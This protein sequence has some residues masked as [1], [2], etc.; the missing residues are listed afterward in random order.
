MQEQ[1][2][3]SY[4]ISFEVEGSKALFTDPLSRIGKEKNSYPVPTASALRGICENIYW[5]P[6]IDYRITECRVMNEI[7]YEAINQSV[8]HI[9]DGKNDL[10][11]YKY[12]KNVRYQV[13]GYMIP[14]PKRPDL[15]E[16]YGPKHLDIFQRS[17][18]AGGRY[19]PYLGSSECM[20]FVSPA[21]FGDGEGYYDNL[22]TLHI[23]VMYNV[24]DYDQN[25]RAKGTVLFD[26][27]MRRGT[28]RFPAEE[29][30]AYY[31]IKYPEKSRA[32]PQKEDVDL[33]DMPETVHS[34]QSLRQLYPIAVEHTD[35]PK[36]R[37]LPP[38]HIG[39]TS[40]ITVV[41]T[42]NGKFSGAYANNADDAATAIPVTLE[43]ACRTAAPAPH[44]L[45][46]KLEYLCSEIPTPKT[47]AYMKQINELQNPPAEV[48]AIREYLQAQTLTKDIAFLRDEKG[49]VQNS[50]VAF[51]DAVVRFLVGD[52]KTWEATHIQAYFDDVASAKVT[53]QGL[54]Y[55]TGQVTNTTIR[56][57]GKIRADADMTKL[58]SS[59]DSRGLVFRDG[60][61]ADAKECVSL[62]YDSSQQALSTLRWLIR[63][64][65]IHI[66]SL[67]CLLWTNHPEQNYG[68]QL[69]ELI[70]QWDDPT[71]AT[72]PIT[73]V[74]WLLLDT[75]DGQ[76]TKGRLS[77]C[78][79]GF[80]PGSQALDNLRYWYQSNR[81][82][83]W[84][85]K[86]W[87][88]G[89]P[90]L[91]EIIHT[92]YGAAGKRWEAPEAVL[93]LH[94]R[95]LIPGILQG[96]QSKKTLLRNLETRI[97]QPLKL[98]SWN[99][100]AC[101]QVYRALTQVEDIDTQSLAYQAGRLLRNYELLLYN[102]PKFADSFSN[103]WHPFVLH[104]QTAWA[105]QM[106]PILTILS[107][108]VDV[109]DILDQRKTLGT[110]DN[111]HMNHHDLILGYA[112]QFSETLKK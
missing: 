97:M 71:E 23:G 86:K 84:R 3:Q 83:V 11:I 112:D 46:E 107:K 19:S 78:G 98:P 74:H 12:L 6:T 43:S 30:C 69:N 47:D 92:A 44:L 36:D 33:A 106:S 81:G 70:L 13:K 22:R 68:K 54:D 56:T 40:Q 29:Q 53:Q 10:S 57:V 76:G 94:I 65:G 58:I 25:G 37:P 73:D 101:V 62:G 35:D 103:I 87:V 7:Q 16:D 14:N 55:L 8:P 90:S 66:G 82:K 24:V 42:P 41:L 51:K 38:S 1:E 27:Y 108:T 34:L 75:V 110:L 80:L 60:S 72:D 105:Y 93:R 48:C 20:A 96:N 18:K 4:L 64:Q 2:V 111:S 9:Y 17:V 52:V 26:C 91:L 15:I 99:W 67:T 32:L 102:I 49:C 63:R 95:E 45:T 5:K 104:P 50:K 85:D 28:I 79:E 100:L 59:N 89:S 21:K 61:F 88:D 109:T 39:A 31:D 77:V